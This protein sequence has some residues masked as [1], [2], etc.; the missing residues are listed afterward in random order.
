[1]LVISPSV[2]ALSPQRGD[3]ILSRSLKPLMAKAGLP[4]CN[5]QTPRRSDAT[6]LA[7]SGIHPR[8]ARR[9]LGH[10]DVATTMTIDQQAPDGRQKKAANATGELIFGVRN[11]SGKD[12][13]SAERVFPAFLRSLSKEKSRC[14]SGRSG[15]S[16]GLEPATWPLPTL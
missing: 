2:D 4:A 16:A 10:S 13:Q 12:G 8:T 5:F 14:V 15:R 9:W 1:V 11:G 6:F 3:N 7:L